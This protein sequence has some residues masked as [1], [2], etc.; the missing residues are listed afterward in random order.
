MPARRPDPTIPHWTERASAVA[1]VVGVVA[2]VIS[3]AVAVTAYD[4]A[5]HAARAQQRTTER[6]AAFEQEQSAPVLAP[7]TPASERGRTITAVSD[8]RQ[9]LKRADWLI[10]GPD[11]HLVIPT[12]NGGAGIAL[13]VG[14]PLVVSDCEHEPYEL[15]VR[16]VGRLGTYVVP[17]GGTDELAYFEP[18]QRKPAYRPGTA[19]RRSFNWDYARFGKR[20]APRMFSLLLWYT[21]GAQRMLRWTC[22][23]YDRAPRSTHSRVEGNQYRVDQ[24]LYGKRPW[25]AGHPGT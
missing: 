8:Y 9:T 21:D 18:D 15:G 2:T 17:S 10:V 12:R 24:A 6:Q 14:L 3:V 13:T 19:G 5:N 11:G 7:S 23:A 22:T 16:S 25:P 20:R 4:K 1:A